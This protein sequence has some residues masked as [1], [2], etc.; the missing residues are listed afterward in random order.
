MTDHNPLPR[1][2]YCGGEMYEAGNS[3]YRWYMCPRCLSGS[4]RKSIN[5]TEYPTER[6]AVIAALQKA[7]KAAMNLWQEPNRVLTMGEV[8]ALAYAEYHVLSVEYRA[9]IKGAENVFRPCVIAHDSLSMVGILELY[10]GASMT[11]MEKSMYGK[12]WRCWLRKPTAEEMKG[13]PWAGGQRE[14]D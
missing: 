8:Q 11:L 2:P 9:I 3:T 10:D 12:R 13:T 14:K 6:L 4:P 5:E 1:C 7:R